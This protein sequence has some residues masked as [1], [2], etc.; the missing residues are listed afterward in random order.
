MNFI[1]QNQIERQDFVDNAVFELLQTLN[2]TDKQFCWDIE[3]IGDIR[4]LIQRYIVKK[5][6]C[7][8]EVFYPWC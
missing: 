8:E 3:M 6:N 7:V 4:D 1:N 5:T 2:P